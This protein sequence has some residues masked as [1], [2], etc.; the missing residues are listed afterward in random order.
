MIV[1][2]LLKTKLDCCQE[3]RKSGG[4]VCYSPG[5]EIKTFELILAETKT[6]IFFAMPFRVTTPYSRKVS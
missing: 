4:F 6:F 3:N 1:R 2:P 5:G